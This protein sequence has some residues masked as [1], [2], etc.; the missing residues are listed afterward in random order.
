VRK[1]GIAMSRVRRLIL[2]T[3][4][5]LALVAGVV[6]LLIYREVRQTRLNQALI[7]AARH[8][9]IAAVTALL[10]QGA[11]VRA[12]ETPAR[13]RSWKQLALELIFRQ[14]RKTTGPTPLMAAMD[15]L[16][17]HRERAADYT[18]VVV[19]LLD[20]RADANDVDARTLTP[21]I[22]AARLGCIEM[23]RTLL[24]HGAKVDVEDF[25]HYT[26]LH[27]VTWTN[28]L[29][30]ARLLLDRGADVNHKDDGGNDAL[31]G[32]ADADSLKMVR[33]LVEHGANPKA[34]NKM[35]TGALSLLVRAGDTA[36]VKLLLSHGADP[37]ATDAMGRTC[38]FWLRGKPHSEI[39]A[40]LRQ[41]GATR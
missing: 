39:A 6:C 30:I 31:I 4:G 38:L 13:S 20:R 25:F 17:Q 16:P 11:D 7:A 22:I 21:L 33:L 9:N 41:S 32:A 37:G 14:R 15:A 12:R 5:P 23:V 27:Y 28:N 2:L 1:E 36:G 18:R 40:L 10:A 19:S 34:T 3:L 35:G 29:E 8:G 24:D 26:P